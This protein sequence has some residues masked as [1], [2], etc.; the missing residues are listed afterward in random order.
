MAQ[1]TGMTHFVVVRLR[2]LGKV[3]QDTVQNQSKIFVN[4]FTVIYCKD[5][6]SAAFFVK[7]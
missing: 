6:I 1:I 3:F 2:V 7:S 5:V 4:N